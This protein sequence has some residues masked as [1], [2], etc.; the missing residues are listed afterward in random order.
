VAIL[1]FSK[2]GTNRRL[3]DRSVTYANLSSELSNTVEYVASLKQVGLI[4]Y[5]KNKDLIIYV[6]RA[7]KHL[8]TYLLYF[9]NFCS[10]Y[11]DSA[12]LPFVTGRLSRF[13]IRRLID[14][15]S[16]ST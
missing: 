5:A 3:W 11:L 1:K 4:K 10:E 15:L 12:L 6:E 9:L 16:S 14:A 7:K 13:A 8:C 2:S